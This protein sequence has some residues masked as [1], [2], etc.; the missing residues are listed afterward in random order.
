M[1][2]S[3][4]GARYYILHSTVD[5]RHSTD[6]NREVITSL[7]EED[8]SVAPFIAEGALMR[9]NAGARCFDRYREHFGLVAPRAQLD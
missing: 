2:I 3:N 1:D 8:P 7:V 4:E 6:W 9:L 5:L